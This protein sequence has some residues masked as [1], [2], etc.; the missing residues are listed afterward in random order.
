MSFARGIQQYRQV[1]AQTA[2][3]ADPHELVRMLMD[4]ALERVA[5]AHGAMNAGQVA[6]RGECVSR[7]IAILDGLRVSLNRDAGGELADNLDGLYDYMQRRLLEAN[8]R[9]DPAGLDEVSALLREIRGAWVAI[10]AEARGAPDGDDR[11]G[12]LG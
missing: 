11:N 1:G 10:P 7:A 6:Q 4:G 3:Y 9:A 8:L 2:R 12:T 5:E